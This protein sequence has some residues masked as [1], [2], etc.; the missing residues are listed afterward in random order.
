M[1]DDKS[2]SIDNDRQYQKALAEKDAARRDKQTANKMAPV[3][4]KVGRYFEDYEIGVYKE[5]QGNKE[6]AVWKVKPSEK[7]I[8]YLKAMNAKG[9]HIFIRP[10]FK[11]EDRFMLHDDLDR[12]GL[13]KHHKHNGR[14]KPGRMVVE[15]SPGNYQVWVRSNRPLSVEEKKHWLAKM[16]SDP[17]ASPRHRWGR[18]PGFRNR[19]A[20]CRTERGYPLSRLVWVDWRYRAQ[21][22][23]IELEPAPVAINAPTSRPHKSQHDQT[24]ELPTRDQ[25]YKGIDRNGKVRESEQDFAYAMALLRRDVPRDVIEE[26]IRQERTEWGN[27]KG[28]KRLASYLKTTLDNAEEKVSRTQSRSPSRAANARRSRTGDYKLT[29]K[30]IKSGKMRTMTVRDIPVHQ[31]QQKLKHHG[32][33]A[34]A[35]MGYQNTGNLELSVQ[36]IAKQPKARVI[37]KQISVETQ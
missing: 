17:G 25:Y 24:A 26:R 32:K 27:H 31:A 30:D 20:K 6:G 13:E 37:E 5:A 16:D 15:S 28:E 33:K 21:V 4:E 19:K 22:P 9:N 23:N 8:G 1:D 35:S 29:V 10:T 12:K 7:T 3:L 36:R 11:N 18:S 14:W 34:I 2:M